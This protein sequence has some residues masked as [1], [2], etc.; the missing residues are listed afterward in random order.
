MLAVHI[1][2]DLCRA[3]NTSYE[4]TTF[5]FFLTKEVHCVVL[6]ECNVYCGFVFMHVSVYSSDYTLISSKK[7]N[8]EIAKKYL[9]TSSYV[10]LFSLSHGFLKAEILPSVSKDLLVKENL[11]AEEL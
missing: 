2:W 5:V 1:S 11:N 8:S 9:F 6:I 7:I 4:A 10:F 3:L